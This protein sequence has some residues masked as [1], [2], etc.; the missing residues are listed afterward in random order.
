MSDYTRLEFTDEEI[1]NYSSYSWPLVCHSC[2]SGL[3]ARIRAREVDGINFRCEV[4]GKS[5]H[6]ERR[7]KIVRISSPSLKAAGCFPSSTGCLFFV[8]VI[9]LLI[10]KFGAPGFLQHLP[11]FRMPSMDF[12]RASGFMAHVLKWT[13]YLAAFLTL[14]HLPVQ[15]SRW[16]VVRRL[17]GRIPW[18]LVWQT[19]VYSLKNKLLRF[20]LIVLSVMFFTSVVPFALNAIG[21]NLQHFIS[22]FPDAALAARVPTLLIFIWQLDRVVG[23]LLPPSGLLLGTAKSVNV[24]LV[25][26]L[27]GK[28]NPYRVVSLLDIKEHIFEP[29]V[30]RVMY[31]NFRTAN[32]HEWRTVVH[33]LMDV[34][35]RII[36]DTAVR[37]VY[38]DAELERIERFGYGYKVIWFS[39][40]AYGNEINANE[41]GIAAVVKGAE[42]LGLALAPNILK[43]LEES[44]DAARRWKA[45]KQYNAMIRSVPRLFRFDSDINSM[46]MKAHFILDWAMVNYMRDCK[47]YA[48]DAQLS[49]LLEDIPSKV[50]PEE[51]EAYLRQSRGLD[52]VRGIGFSALDLAKN[53]KGPNQE[54]NIANAH[55][56]IGKC[57]RFSRD[58][59]SALHHLGKGIEML[60]HMVQIGHQNAEELS[61]D[62]LELTIA[63][64]LRG[65]VY[66]ARYRQTRSESDRHSAAADFE[67]S[68]GLD[69]ELGK[70][71]PEN[72][73]RLREL[74]R[75]T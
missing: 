74:N 68:S 56:K 37:T 17:Y 26:V 29:F 36:V 53:T 20:Q 45:Q 63:H 64:F 44:N 58:W 46:L 22:P 42:E 23:Y 61:T 12:P 40:G 35:P 9:V 48:Q 69:R 8:A 41:S 25:A 5:N 38:V 15:F 21:A 13:G 55:V 33:H 2:G 51:E 6:V 73:S 4:C 28:L 70:D 43:G 49:E 30:T 75:Q 14:V 47:Q 60:S 72:A 50:S 19:G 52:E 32:G 1:A 65:E 3:S 24:H 57:A 31:N 54:F 66:M 59:E 7:A 11:S 16:R 27:H 10:S 62:R 34:V 71:S 18:S 39:S 67:A